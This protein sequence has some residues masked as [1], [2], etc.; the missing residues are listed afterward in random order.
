[1][2]TKVEQQAVWVLTPEK[3][4]PTLAELFQ[5]VAYW[6]CPTCGFL[7]H[8]LSAFHCENCGNHFNAVKPG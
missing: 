2:E 8:P 3:K 1:M 5:M 7:N 4:L 6:T